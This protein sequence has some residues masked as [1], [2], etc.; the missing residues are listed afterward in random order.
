[1]IT[2]WFD[3]IYMFSDDRAVVVKDGKWGYIDLNGHVVIKPVYDHAFAFS[4][5]TA[6]VVIGGKMINIDKEGNEID[7]ENSQNN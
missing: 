1:M 7:D 5:G 3:Q 2:D 4:N 6:I